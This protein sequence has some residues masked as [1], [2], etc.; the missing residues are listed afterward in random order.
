MIRVVIDTNVL[1][2]GVLTPRGHEAAVL[3]LIADGVLTWSLSEPILQEYRRVLLDKLHF[4]PA[5]AQWYFG[6]QFPVRVDNG[7]RSATRGS[8]ADEGVRPTLAGSSIVKK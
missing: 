4:D 2:S 6:L 3:D 1:V 5:Q 8:R 7:P